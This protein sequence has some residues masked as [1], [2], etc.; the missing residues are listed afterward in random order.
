MGRP[1]A[2]RARLPPSPWPAL[3]RPRSRVGRRSAPPPPRGSPRSPRTAVGVG[4]G[5]VARGD[6]GTTR[7]AT[8]GIAGQTSGDDDDQEHAVERIPAGGSS[9]PRRRSRCGSTSPSSHQRA[10]LHLDAHDVEA[11]RQ[12]STTAAPPPIRELLRLAFVREQHRGRRAGGG[13]APPQT[14]GSSATMPRRPRRTARARSRAATP[15]AEVSSRWQ[16]VPGQRTAP[17]SRRSARSSGGSRPARAAVR[18]LRLARFVDHERRPGLGG[19]VDHRRARHLGRSARRE[20]ARRPRP[21]RSG[22]G[23]GTLRRPP[24]HTAALAA[25]PPGRTRPRPCTSPRSSSPSGVDPRRSSRRPRSPRPSGCLAG[26]GF[27]DESPDAPARRACLHPIHGGGRRGGVP[28]RGAFELGSC[29]GPGRISP[30]PARTSRH[31][32]P[33]AGRVVP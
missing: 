18:R 17:A 6:A 8:Q 25:L 28:S 11:T 20:G 19:A 31:A 21:N 4:P 14:S 15:A 3:P 23:R 2:S 33:A 27:G 9:R 5:L 10:L 22:R 1:R 13:T 7:H 12:L 16:R 29:I 32:R 30:R 26:Y 24:A